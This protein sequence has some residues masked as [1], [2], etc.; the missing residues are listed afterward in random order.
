MATEM[1]RKFGSFARPIEQAAVNDRQYRAMIR[2]NTPFFQS[3]SHKVPTHIFRAEYAQNKLQELNR[4]QYSGFHEVTKY[5]RA[6]HDST[7]KQLYSPYQKKLRDSDSYQIGSYRASYG[8]FFELSQNM[9]HNRLDV[10]NAYL[11]IG[12]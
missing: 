4:K 6:G 7:G 8:A 9:G 3:F 11:G 1:E 5:R 12:R 10:L 2:D